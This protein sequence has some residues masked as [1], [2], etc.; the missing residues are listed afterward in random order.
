MNISISTDTLNNIRRG[1]GFLALA[2]LLIP[3]G[4]LMLLALG[5][6]TTAQPKFSFVGGANYSHMVDSYLFRLAVRNSLLVT[7]LALLMVMPLS[8]LVVRLLAQP[9]AARYLLAVALLVPLAMPVALGTLAWGET[10]DFFRM[11]PTMAG[12]A[13][14]P[15]ALVHT[16][17]VLPITTVILVAPS[18][19]PR[20]TRGGIAATA[21]AYWI[22]AD[23]SVVLLLT[24][25]EQFNASHLLSSWAFTTAVNSG[26]IGL[27]A[28]MLMTL[29]IVL[30]IFAM[31]LGWLAANLATLA[32]DN[33]VAA[34]SAPIQ[35]VLTDP[36]MPILPPQLE[37]AIARNGVRWTALGLVV[38]ALILPVAILLA[39]L[40]TPDRSLSSYL[41]ITLLTP[42]LGWLGATLL[43][44]AGA[45]AVTIF[46]AP[47]VG[48]ILA[49]RHRRVRM[50]AGSGT[51]ALVLS[52]LPVAYVALLWLQARSDRLTGILRLEGLYIA[53][54]VCL[55]IGFVAM[56][57]RALTL[58][59]YS[60]MTVLAMMSLI[61]ITQE[62]S[63]ATALD[64]SRTHSINTGVVN[65]IAFAAG[66]TDAQLATAILAPT[67]VFVL[68]YSAL[69]AATIL[70]YR[71]GL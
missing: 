26:A 6:A 47:F 19:L 50:S 64:N 58:G 68:I 20:W 40:K 21:A 9:G 7:G 8:S 39:Q 29:L 46:V 63:N 4:L 52:V 18:R 28:A 22:L 44:A 41:D 37:T 34:G 66:T 62:F 27:G 56:S 14:L 42:Y 55:G 53:A 67:L 25:G 24:G 54:A 10:F 11:D 69:A 33:L 15:F 61:L 30:R 36:N 45:T 57:Q 71:K 59:R 16:W 32:E 12:R 49:A 13:I 70:L 43:L 5:D 35:T 17:R 51:V 60:T 65:F 3:L 48:M 31:V 2:L 38:G 23:V 1:L